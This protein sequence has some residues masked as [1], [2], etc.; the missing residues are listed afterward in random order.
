M[1]ESDLWNQAIDTAIREIALQSTS[2][3]LQ[4]YCPEYVVACKDCIR[5]LALLKEPHVTEQQIAEM[6]IGLLAGKI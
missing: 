4:A 6:M 5:R 2:R 1:M 3:H